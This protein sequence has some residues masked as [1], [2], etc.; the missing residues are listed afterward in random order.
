MLACVL[1]RERPYR[2][3]IHIH[4][5]IIYIFIH[6]YEHIYIYT[7]TYVYL[8]EGDTLEWLTGCCPARLTMA[9]YQNRRSNNP[10]V[11]QS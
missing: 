1:K 7:H 8:Y 5:Y 2:M 6:I 9:V 3:N 11:V 4:T 10:I